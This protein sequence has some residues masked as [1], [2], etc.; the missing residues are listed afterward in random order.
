MTSLHLSVGRCASEDLRERRGPKA[1]GLEGHVRGA[2]QV[3]AE[4]TVVIVELQ[5]NGA[6]LRQITHEIRPL[7]RPAQGGDLLAQHD[8]EDSLVIVQPA[9]VLA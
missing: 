6:E 7:D 3:G 4:Q 1:D 9:T 5:A 2:A 8:H